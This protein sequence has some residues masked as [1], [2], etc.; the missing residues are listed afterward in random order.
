MSVDLTAALRVP[1]TLAATLSQ[2]R[3]TLCDLLGTLDVPDLTIFA[4]RQYQQGVQTDPGRRLD[5]AE[6]A[7]TIIGDPIAADETGQSGS[8]HFEIDVPTTGDSVRLTV[9]DYHH[10]QFDENRR[11]REAVFSPTRTCVGV[12]V[13]TALALATAQL[14]HGEYIDEEIRMLQPEVHEPEQVIQH[15]QLPKS[16]T[17]FATQCEKYLRQF[18][19]L[20]GWPQDR[21]M[22]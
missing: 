2:T 15:T 13:A 21:S 1:I 19:N 10:E 12:V 11:Q 7:T 6:L 14:T 18:P 22:R 8:I 16:D 4:E 5:T 9:I 20:E 17:D 3:S